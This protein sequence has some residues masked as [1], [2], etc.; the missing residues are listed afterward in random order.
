MQ[1]ILLTFTLA[2]VVVTQ[3]SGNPGASQGG[4]WL[5]QAYNAYE[6]RTSQACS[7]SVAG[8]CTSNSLTR[9]V[10]DTSVTYN[11]YSPI[12]V[13]N[14]FLLQVFPSQEIKWTP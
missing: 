7:N 11:C 8:C 13:P 6:T 2:A 10:Q 1:T 12:S 3:S 4:P 14:D 5:L 9:L